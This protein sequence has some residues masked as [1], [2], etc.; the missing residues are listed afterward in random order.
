MSKFTY[1]VQGEKG[2]V[3]II[4]DVIDGEI[5]DESFTP[6]RHLSLDNSMH[7]LR[8]NNLLAENLDTILLEY[9]ELTEKTLAQ[10]MSED[11]DAM[12]QDLY[13]EEEWILW[14]AI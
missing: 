9:A 2:D 14:K 3:E 12:E 4:Y 8:E 5:Y 1:V 7:I 10:A 6:L 13:G 11:Y